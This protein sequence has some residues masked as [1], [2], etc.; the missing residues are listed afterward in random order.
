MQAPMAGNAWLA[1]L[2]VLVLGGFMAILDTSIVNVALPR[3]MNIFGVDQSRIEWVATAYTLALG[4]ITPLSGWLGLKIGLK[5]MYLIAL[6]IFTLASGLCAISW[7]L[8]SQIA[9]R[10]IQALGGG[11]IMPAVQAIMLRIV[12]RE[13]MGA[14][15][16]ILGMALLLAPAVGPSLG[17]YLVEYIDWRWIYTINIPIGVIAVLLA[18]N[19]VP[20]FPAGKAGKFDL[21]GAI[22][23]AISLFTLLLATTEGS[24][25]GWSS[26][27]IVSLLFTSL[28][29]M[30]FFVWWQFTTDEP[31]LNL[32][33]FKYKTFTIANILLS[34]IT[35]SMFGILFYLPVYLQTIRGLG[36]F[37]SGLLQLPPALLTGLFLP[38][39]G[40]LYDRIGPKLLVPVGMVL[41]ALGIYLFKDLTIDTPLTYVVLWNCVRSV[42]MG[43]AMIPTQSSSVS[44]IPTEQAGQASAITNVITRVASSFGVVLMVQ[45]FDHFSRLEKSGF[46]NLLQ[47]NDPIQQGNMAA[48]I[49]KL[50]A[51]GLTVEKARAAYLA[52]LQAKVATT[53]F[54]NT[55]NIVMVII[56]MAVV[57][58]AVLGLFLRK[59]KVASPNA[60]T[61]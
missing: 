44:E 54:T 42:G 38:I 27:S 29:T 61:K 36:A 55:F 28:M 46:S 57:M 31:L 19:H 56:A 39:S 11:L 26:Q 7:D 45:L 43:L 8:N 21:I 41:V 3:M 6:V 24:S 40:S 17:G 22:S 25:W 13:K 9:F 58:C 51:S 37:Q 10:V 16:G 30:I 5:N 48:G 32:K 14:A 49:A 33:L 18:Y 59:G 1:P 47:N 15:S 50:Q 53:A 35:I 60:A 52:L 20:S 12:P 4:V 34:L 23:I 2:L